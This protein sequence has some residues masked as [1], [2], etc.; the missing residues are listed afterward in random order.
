MTGAASDAVIGSGGVAFDAA[1]ASAR[2]T[3]GLDAQ[4][5]A[6]TWSVARTLPGARDFLLVVFGDD[7]HAAAIAAVDPVSGEVLESARLPE[8][9]PHV[10]LSAS[11]AIDRAGFGP[12]TQARLVWDPSAASR[13][14]FYPLWQLHCEGRT[15]WVDSVRG[16]VWPKLDSAK[17]GGS[18][19]P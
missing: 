4:V 1:I 12:D 3:L 5:S 7:H 10:L 9:N 18:V 13:S 14:P 6:R 11:E 17:A 19:R 16:T 2:A 8:R 15:V